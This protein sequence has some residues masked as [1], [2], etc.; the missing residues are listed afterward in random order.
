MK[1][2]AI[3][4]DLDNTLL[5]FTKS[6]EESLHE[7]YCHFFDGRLPEDVFTT[8][9]LRINHELW[10]SVE[11]GKMSPV[12]LKTER[13]SRFLDEQNL[14]LNPHLLAEFYEKNL[15]QN[16]YWFNGAEKLLQTLREQFLIGIVTNGLTTV[17]RRKYQLTGLDQW[18]PC[19]VISEEIGIAKPE[20]EIFEIAL[21]QLGVTAEETLMVGDSVS[22]DFKGAVAMGM[23][24]CWVSPDEHPLPEELKA[25]Q[26]RVSAVEMLGGLL[27]PTSPT[28]SQ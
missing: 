18:C 26:F 13:F 20:K 19:Y 23:D 11:L 24:F 2:S 8:E 1:Y 14:K 15:G 25:P 12:E 4:F 22:S 9:F 27:F 7:L 17:Q 10:K 16:I 5:D 21:K 3:L 28:S 6:E